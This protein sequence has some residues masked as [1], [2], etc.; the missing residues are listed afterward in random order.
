MNTNA[1]RALKGVVL[2]AVAAALLLAMPSQAFAQAKIKI[3]IWEFENH[4]EQLLVLLEAGTGR[5]RPDRHRVFR[6]PA[7]VIRL[8]RRGTRQAEPGAE[9]TG[10]RHI[11]RRGPGECGQSRQDSGREVHHHWRRRQVQASTTPRARIGALR[12]R[13][14]RRSGQRHRSTSASSTRPPLNESSR[15]R[16]TAKSRRAA[17]SSRARP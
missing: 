3:A 11:R 12:R 4:A 9:G 8:Q 13:R 15:S 17:A 7:T 14:Q 5:A 2:G 6:K 1:T 10:P 16:P